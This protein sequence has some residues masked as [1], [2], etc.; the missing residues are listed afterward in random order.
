[1]AFSS[2][3]RRICFFFFSPS[4]FVYNRTYRDFYFRAAE[5]LAKSEVKCRDLV[6]R[7][8]THQTANNLKVVLD[9][10]NLSAASSF[11]TELQ[12][13]RGQWPV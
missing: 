13:D 12:I 6:A 1:M 9:K 4:P 8:V 3:L 11:P 10:R 7:P 2:F 5:F